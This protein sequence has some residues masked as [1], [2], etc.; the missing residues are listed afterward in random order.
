MVYSNFKGTQAEGRE[1]VNAINHNCNCSYGL[2]GMRVS[3][4]PP[5]QAM[6]DDQAWLDTLLFERWRLARVAP[7]A[8][9]RVIDE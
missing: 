5:H 3:T 1:L 2:F 8:A 6:I 9:K 7:D 4:C